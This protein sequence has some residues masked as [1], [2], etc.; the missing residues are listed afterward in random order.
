MIFRT[1]PPLPEIPDDSASS[2]LE[3]ESFVE[4][5]PP[6]VNITGGPL[7]YSYQVEEVHIHFGSTTNVGSEHKI[8]GYAFPAEVREHTLQNC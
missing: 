7:V 3:E 2:G 1:S 8:D 4:V 6:P 5:G